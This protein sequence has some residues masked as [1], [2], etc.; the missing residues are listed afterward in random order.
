MKKVYGIALLIFALLAGALAI[1]VLSDGDS[2]NTKLEKNVK[3]RW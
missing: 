1:S 2:D 3:R